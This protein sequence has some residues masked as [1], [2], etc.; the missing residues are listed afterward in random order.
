MSL[1]WK[2]VERRED[3]RN[4]K[5]FSDTIQHV[6]QIQKGHSTDGKINKNLIIKTYNNISM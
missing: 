1:Q 2:Y 5:K 4:P 3:Q 6:K